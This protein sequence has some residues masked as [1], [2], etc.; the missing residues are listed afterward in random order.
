MPNPC[1]SPATAPTSNGSCPTVA[2]RAVL[3]RRVR[4]L[5][6]PPRT[7]ARSAAPA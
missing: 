5:G 4:Q 3:G 7:V 2:E 1:A 6:G